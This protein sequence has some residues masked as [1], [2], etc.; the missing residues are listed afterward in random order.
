M[1]SRQGAEGGARRVRGKVTEWG[2]GVRAMT[3]DFGNSF[4][5]RSMRAAVSVTKCCT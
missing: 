5:S 2:A 4:F 3:V 1:I